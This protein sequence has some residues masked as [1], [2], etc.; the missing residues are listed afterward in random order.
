MYYIVYTII[1]KLS[2]GP[3][4]K[5]NRTA[6]SSHSPEPAHG[7]RR[8][9]VQVSASELVARPEEAAGPGLLTAHPKGLPGPP[10][11][12]EEILFSRL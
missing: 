12:F 5:T 10:D 2:L 6:L 1:H 11:V 9:T 4:P 3:F 8:P 7:K